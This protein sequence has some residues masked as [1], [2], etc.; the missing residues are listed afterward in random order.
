MDYFESGPRYRKKH[1]Q[2]SK[3]AKRSNHKHD[4]EKVIIKT[5]IGWRW[6]GRCR[7]CGRINSGNGFSSKEFVR[8]ESRYKSAIS[9]SDFYSAAELQRIY[10]DVGIEEC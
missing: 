1:S 10:P 8:P 7:I 5:L 2:K 6:G 9:R 3:S 4:Y